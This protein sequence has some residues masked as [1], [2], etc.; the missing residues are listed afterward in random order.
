MSW[1]ER[2]ERRLRQA[3]FMPGRTTCACNGG[4][5]KGV[6]Y[7]RHNLNRRY[8][9]KDNRAGSFDVPRTQVLVGMVVE[10]A[11]VRGQQRAHGLCFQAPHNPFGALIS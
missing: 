9:K 11:F 1:S 3:L 7:D 10:V 5:A 4:G 8:A 2:L 6:L